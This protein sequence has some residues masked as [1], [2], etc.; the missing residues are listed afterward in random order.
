MARDKYHE[1]VKRLLI[2]EGWRV[3][4]DP[5]FI[6]TLISKLEVDLGAEKII[7]AEKGQIKIAVEIK[8]FLGHSTMH[9]FYKALG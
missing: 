7:A 2:E 5:L 4:D 9:D 1:L 8:S 6:K 3:T